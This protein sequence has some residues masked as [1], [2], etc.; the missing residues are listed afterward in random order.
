M[1]VYENFAPGSAAA[2]DLLKQVRGDYESRLSF[3]VADLGTPAGR[4][5]ANRYGLREGQAL[6]LDGAGGILAPL[7][8]HAG[9][10]PLRDSLQR[11]LPMLP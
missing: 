10:Q 8:V 11:Q 4:A 2:L 5:F 1:L 6:L 9:E 7:A 3:V